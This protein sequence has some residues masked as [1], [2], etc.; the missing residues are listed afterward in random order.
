MIAVLGGLADVERDLIRTRTA[1]GRSRAKAQGKHMGRPAS[2]NT[3]SA[4]RGQQTPRAR[5]YIAGIGGQLRPQH[6]HHAPRYA[7]RMSYPRF[8]WS[9]CSL[10]SVRYRSRPASSR[11][12]RNSSFVPGG[13]GCLNSS[14][15]SR[16]SFS[17][18]FLASLSTAAS[19]ISTIA[20]V[21][22]LFRVVRLG[23]GH[24]FSVRHLMDFLYKCRLCACPRQ[25]RRVRDSSQYDAN[26]VFKRSAVIIKFIGRL[27][28]FTKQMGYTFSAARHGRPV[29]FARLSI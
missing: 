14:C 7:H 18:S 15:H 28:D 20:F 1:G 23:E 2:L 26:Q 17:A 25:P 8:L 4:E 24:E 10:A 13:S 22:M 5:R 27:K 11:I 16:P 12:G 21:P 19:L 3:G 9:H 29:L 6:I